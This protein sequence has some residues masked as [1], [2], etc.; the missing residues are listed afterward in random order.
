MVAKPKKPL[1]PAEIL[2]EKQQTELFQTFAVEIGFLTKTLTGVEQN[3]EYP[4]NG[5]ESIQ[6]AFK[7]WSDKRDE[8]AKAKKK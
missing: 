1:S 6:I 4:Y 7:A 8:K 3:P 5:M 2:K